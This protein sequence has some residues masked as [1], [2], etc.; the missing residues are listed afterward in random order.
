MGFRHSI[1]L[2]GCLANIVS[3]TD[4]SSLSLTLLEME[5]DLPNFD[6]A[7]QGVALSAFFCGYILTQVAG[8]LLSRR[9]GPKHVIIGAVAMWSFAALCTPTA[10]AAGLGWLFA[11]RVLLGLGE[12]VLLP[13]LQDLAVAW[14]PPMERSTATTAMT[15]GQFVGTSV[16]YLAAPMVAAWW[17]SVFYLFGTCGL[18]LCA[19]FG[20]VVTS[21][22]HEHR[23][24]R[25]AEMQ[26]IES[27]REC[28][29][30]EHDQRRLRDHVDVTDTVELH[31][32]HASCS[33]CCTAGA[34][35]VT[36][37]TTSAAGAG[38]GAGDGAG[39]GAQGVESSHYKRHVSSDEGSSSSSSSSDSHLHHAAPARSLV[40]RRDFG[41]VHLGRFLCNRAA[42]VIYIA[43]RA[44][45][46]REI[47]RG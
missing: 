5:N 41:H 4:R 39:D 2:L 31:A 43:V 47:G 21:T 28:D 1:L 46:A 37:A 29:A 30:V 17:P 15:S 40:R 11:A 25:A 38:G 12:G 42:V 20:A 6:K 7:A 13:C 8:G 16:A 14:V 26:L 36:S 19:L 34:A 10:A 24:V 22:P 3:Y 23:C 45:H 33:G 32:T 27:G 35:H 18:V 9:Y 44:P